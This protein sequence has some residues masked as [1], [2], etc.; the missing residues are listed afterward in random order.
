[1]TEGNGN[2]AII[3]PTGTY[4]Y[5]LGRRISDRGTSLLWIMLNPSTADASVDDATI[6]KL[7]GFSTRWGAARFEVVNLF[8]LRSTDP[9]ALRAHSDPVGTE[10]DEHIERAIKRADTI[11]CAWGNDGSFM[12]RDLVVRALVH[13]ARK[14][15]VALKLNNGGKRRQPAHPLYQPYETQAGLWPF[16]Q[17]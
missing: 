2:F 14:T 8:A 6:R 13:E 11:V 5:L 15:P 3:D 17:G 16:V 4:R 1:M 9:Q 7:I 10:N 12:D